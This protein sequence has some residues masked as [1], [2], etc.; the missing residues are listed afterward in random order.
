MEN[1]K[2]KKSIVF[3]NLNLLGKT[4]TTSTAYLPLQFR[5]LGIKSLEFET[6]IQ[7]VKKSIYL[8]HHPHMN[9]IREKYERLV[10]A[11][12]KNPLTD[13]DFV[14]NTYDLEF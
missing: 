1:F 6:E 7:Y 8:Q 13:A 4:C 10:S 5:G 12:W 3:F 9:N 2:T 11:G 14:L